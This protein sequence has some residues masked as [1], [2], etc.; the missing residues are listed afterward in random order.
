MQLC[1]VRQRQV[2]QWGVL[3]CVRRNRDRY[4]F[5]R[6]ICEFIVSWPDRE[7]ISSLCI[8]VW[9]PDIQDPALCLFVECLNC[10]PVPTGLSSDLAVTTELRQPKRCT[11]EILFQCLLVVSVTSKYKVLDFRFCSCDVKVEFRGSLHPELLRNFVIAV[12]FGKFSVTLLNNSVA[13]N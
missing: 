5:A 10:L 9:S 12:Q 7:Q 4:R 8:K 6:Q 11:Y 13:S 1:G 2:L 3:L